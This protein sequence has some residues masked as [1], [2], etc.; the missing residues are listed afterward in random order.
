M[1]H[2]TNYFQ[3]KTSILLRRKA[4][5]QSCQGSMESITE[6]ACKL[7]RL[8]RECDFGATLAQMLCDIFVI[9][10]R[11]DQL[12]ERLLSE[13]ASVL[14]FEEAIKRAEAFKRA[15]TEWRT[16]H[17]EVSINQTKLH[18]PS[19]SK[20]QVDHMGN[21]NTS[22]CYRCGSREHC[23]NFP[24]FVPTLCLRNKCFIP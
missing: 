2:L 13:D 7:R 1:A 12:G 11:D 3:G 9:G 5:F 17:Q 4:F 19:K 14:T 8:A 20:T 21:S 24:R 6:Y 18:P 16:V 23:A 10:V 22:Y 15:R